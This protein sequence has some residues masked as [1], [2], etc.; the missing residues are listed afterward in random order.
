MSFRRHFYSQERLLRIFGMAR[1]MPPTKRFTKLHRPHKL[2][3]SLQEWMKASMRLL[4]RVERTYLADRSNGFP[5]HVHW[6]GNRG[7][8][9]SMIASLHL[10]SRQMRSFAQLFAKRLHS[11]RCSL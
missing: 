2:Q 8:T 6:L 3:S 1:R 5:L 9:C 4:R 7:S 10:I 11:Q